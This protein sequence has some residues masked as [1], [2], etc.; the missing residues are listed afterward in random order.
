MVTRIHDSIAASSFD[1]PSNSAHSASVE[2]G[3]VLES[4]A[5]GE[6]EGQ[7][8]VLPTEDDIEK[9]FRVNQDGSMTVEMKVHL[10]IKEEETVHWTTTLSRSSVTSQT[11][12]NSLPA[13]EG[14]QIDSV[15]SQS[16]DLQSPAAAMD[17]I[18]NEISEEKDEEPPLQCNGALSNSIDED[19]QMSPQRTPTPGRNRIRQQQASVE[20]ITSVSAEATTEGT[21]TSFSYK[22]Q[23]EHTATTEQ[24][25]MFK[26]KSTKPVP[27]PR[28]FGSVDG[29]SRSVATFES[30][31]VTEFLQV[32]SSGDEVTETVLHIYEQQTCQDNFL[33]N[34]SGNPFCRLS[35]SGTG[36]PQAELWRPSTASESVSMWRA[37][38]I[39]SDLAQ[40]TVKTGE[41]QATNLTKPANKVQRR[42]DGMDKRIGSKPKV[43]NKHGP[44]L[45]PGKRQKEKSAE[46]TKKQTQVKPL[47][48]AGLLKK[49]YGSKLRSAKRTKLRRQQTPQTEDKSPGR[50]EDRHEM[51]PLKEIK[52]D[53]P[54]KSSPL[55]HQ[56]SV[57]PGRRNHSGEETTSLPAFNSLGSAADKYVEKWLEQSQQHTY[58]ESKRAHVA[59]VV[60]QLEMPTETQTS[61]ALKTDLF[62]DNVRRA[63]V[64][65]RILS[66]ETKSSN[67]SLEKKSGQHQITDTDVEV[68]NI[69]AQSDLGGT[70]PASNCCCSENVS[71]VP[72]VSTEGEK[73]SHPSITSLC[74]STPS[75]SL[76]LD[77]PS[78]PPPADT[79]ELL[80]DEEAVMPSETSGMFSRAP[81]GGSQTSDQ[82]SGGSPTSDKLTSS[83]D[84]TSG[85]TT[86]AQADGSSTPLSRAP[87][88]K[89]VALVSNV[90][91]DRK[92]SLR[93]SRL[94][95]YTVS[96]DETLPAPNAAL[97]EN[98]HLDIEQGATHLEGESP[99][100]ENGHSRC[101]SAY[102]ASLESEGT[103][104]TG[105]FSSSEPRAQALQPSET[106]ATL[107]AGS[108]PKRQ[109]A[110]PTLPHSQSLD[111]VS[112]AVRHRSG[113][114]LPGRN[115]SLENG[116]EKQGS[117][118][119]RGKREQ[120][121][122]PTATSS[123]KTEKQVQPQQHNV[124]NQPHMPAVIEELCISLKSIRQMLQRRRP[125]RLERSNSLPDFS[126]HVASSFGSS[127]NALLA[128]LS[129]VT[130]KDGVT[131]CC[132][133]ELRADAVSCAE[134]LKMISSLRE[135]AAI[136]DSHQLNGRL[137]SLQQSASQQLMEGWR[138]FQELGNKCKSC[139]SM[140]D[141]EPE[142]GA[143]DP[144]R[145]SD[146]IINEIMDNLD[147]PEELRVELASLSE[148]VTSDC[149]EREMMGDVSGGH[150]GKIRRNGDG[151]RC[152]S[153]EVESQEKEE[154]E[155]V[156]VKE[157]P[158]SEAESQGG[159]GGGAAPGEEAQVESDGTGY[160]NGAGEDSSDLECPSEEDERSAHN[161][162]EELS[163]RT[164]SLDSQSTHAS[165]EVTGLS[166]SERESLTRTG[167]AAVEDR[168]NR[169][170]EPDSEEE[171][172]EDQR[173]ESK[174][175][176][177]NVFEEQESAEEAQQDRINQDLQTRKD[178]SGLIIEDLCSADE[179]SGNEHSVSE[180]H[181]ETDAPKL[182]CS[183]EEELS[184]YE[185]DL[186]PGPIVN[187]YSSCEYAQT[188]LDAQSDG[189][190]RENKLPNP[191]K[192]VISQTIAERVSLLEKLVTDAQRSRKTPAR[193]TVRCSSQRSPQLQ[194]D[195]EDSESP[196][197]AS[198]SAPQ[199]SLSF[200]YDSSGVV[201]TEPERT[202]VQSIRE[203]FL[204]KSATDARRGNG[205]SPSQP[206]H[207]RAE[208]SVSGGYQSQTSSEASSAEDESANKCVS[209]GF[210]RKTIER[211]Y[212]KKDANPEQEAGERPPS[213]PK[214]KKKDHSR[215]FSPFHNIR[216]KA[217]SE[218]SYFNS[219]NALD[220]LNEATKCVAFKAQVRPGE[221]V[222]GENRPSLI[223]KSVSDPAGINQ[224]I[225]T[226]PRAAEILEDAEEM[227][228]YSLFEL[229]DKNS[230]Q[231]KC[232]YFSLPHASESDMCQDELSTV[233][234]VV[235]NGDAVADAKE[236]SKDSKTP[237]ERNG[238]LP[239]VGTSDFKKM[240]NKVHPLVELPPDGEVVLAQPAR[241]H[242]AVYRRAPEPDVLDLL[243][244]F[245]GQNCPIL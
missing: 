235:T 12:G 59:K 138:S 187:G 23:A 18:R 1:L 231:K 70:Q 107:N 145:G 238:V 243:Y 222:P 227:T 128:F 122:R 80:D 155:T 129:A 150:K 73:R 201:T 67:S 102:S 89:R 176:V 149:K 167:R 8:C 72:K 13:S 196:T 81:S 140:P 103:T 168:V 109:Q 223:R 39:T 25:C 211:L 50:R 55:A 126:S 194:S 134:A 192:D 66:F 78:P 20:S 162:Y 99:T 157:G 95:E 184:Y 22:E 193:L 117:R 56:P 153:S 239:A 60:K 200:S 116:N 64:K 234:R 195:G 181:A 65:E 108:S 171:L 146:D 93:K 10:T 202:R 159:G 71:H 29:I 40:P 34:L 228:P 100:Q 43:S 62:P 105:S 208:T 185:E 61:Q 148:E 114:E 113:N 217:G 44:I 87:S 69:S 219:T 224:G 186:S 2:S 183:A 16:L 173:R 110:Q 96:C 125:S 229:E 26:Q 164:T 139:S 7:D 204:A 98:T 47:T 237:A 158:G 19:V 130:L 94:D 226:P 197:L 131:N 36:G 58:E 188:L 136:E 233:S 161:Y 241:G 11:N 178:K 207:L 216:S 35:S 46:K 169:S 54:G 77:L 189:E 143:K 142:L 24:F 4:V 177:N 75:H 45:S 41:V 6:V 220:T 156:D 124:P 221:S 152:S 57:L 191:P 79:A 85:R 83:V 147:I 182:S 160:V 190:T 5:E 198:R 205:R 42:D 236:Q 203:M 133:D 232:T 21:V 91:F 119:S 97:G 30:A 17:A 244:N 3:H 230:A 74:H 48:G 199:S 76:S 214:Q 88:T 28:R 32:E 163:A 218:L 106:H 51:V 52:E 33:A 104:S 141:S 49:S 84:G 137:L 121:G 209:K 37:E 213:A 14:E 210:V 112:P 166:S 132:R 92:M 172:A 212:G 120:T 180:A 206:P 86:S 170:A 38:S 245:C 27:K 215:N 90:S 151:W 15:T 240:D 154:R 175:I 144:G 111:V 63:S 242:G 68:C 53:V 118:S 31:G 165:E 123:V 174:A 225:A 135:I 115:H 179:D 101:S 127:S 82:P 9:S